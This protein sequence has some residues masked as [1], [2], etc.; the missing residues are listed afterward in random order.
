MYMNI[1]LE[2]NERCWKIDRIEKKKNSQYVVTQDK[3]GCAD[4]LNT[5]VYTHAHTH[6]HSFLSISCFRI[7]AKFFLK[8][9]FKDYFGERAVS[10]WNNSDLCG[11]YKEFPSEYDH[12][13]VFV[14][15]FLCKCQ[16]FM[17]LAFRCIPREYYFSKLHS[18]NPETCG[19]KT[20]QNKSSSLF[21]LGHC[22]AK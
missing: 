14:K 3:T 7:S 8:S 20:K 4:W 16:Y 10:D 13:L 11:Y 17:S 1:H 6:T 18:C 12:L 5:H 19:L 9:L 2:N 21:G 22:Q 15:S